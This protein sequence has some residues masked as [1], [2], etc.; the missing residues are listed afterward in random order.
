MKVA[1]NWIRTRLLPY[2]WPASFAVVPLILLAVLIFNQTPPRAIDEGPGPGNLREAVNFSANPK[3]FETALVAMEAPVDLGNGVIATALT[4][5]GTVP[6]PL[7]RLKVGEQVT[8]HFT[9][10]LPIPASIHWHG[11][12]LTNRSDGTGIT[13]DAVPVGGT[14]TYDFIV[15][16]P[17]VYFYHS[18]IAPTNPSFKGFYGTIIVEDPTEQALKTS[19]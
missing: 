17:G 8:V 10:N 16:R 2:M 4:F 12:E 7:F 14:Y 1:L 11:I 18:H 9:N 15:P 5:N 19:K 13:Q 6:G 3:K